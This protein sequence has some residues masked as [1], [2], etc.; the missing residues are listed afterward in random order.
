MVKKDLRLETEQEKLKRQQQLAKESQKESL[1]ASQVPEIRGAKERIFQQKFEP[2]NIIRAD[3]RA[4][5]EALN[6]EVQAAQNLELL[7]RENLTR[8][9]E[10]ERLGA[11]QII[12]AEQIPQRQAA[13]LEEKPQE[14]KRL[15]SGLLPKSLQ[16]IEEKVNILGK[17][18]LATGTFEKPV[19]RLTFGI[20]K[21]A[22][23]AIDQISSAL[24]SKKDVKQLVAEQALTDTFTTLTDSIEQLKLGNVDASEIIE[25]FDLVQEK[26]D[27][28]ES[29]LHGSNKLRLRY[30]LTEGKDIETEVRKRKKQLE[31]LRENIAVAAQ[32]GELI[33]AR[34]S[35]G[36]S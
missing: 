16:G 4:R 20:V 22:V 21:L 18:K 5:E 19:K 13:V 24:Q 9:A 11:T 17:E 30:F 8:R 29:L 36:L 23:N 28:L 10:Q 1:A 25:S 31:F 3:L 14:E 27:N 15:V 35:F 2:E 7:R 33:R 32:Q 6:P 34:A 26:I 12:P